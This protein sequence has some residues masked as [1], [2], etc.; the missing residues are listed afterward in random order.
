MPKIA[1][2]DKL[3]RLAYNYIKEKIL[4]GEY[5]PGEKVV[6]ARLSEELNMSRTPIRKAINQLCH[7]NYL[8]YKPNK[9][10]FVS[11][12]D[13]GLPEYISRLRLMELLSIYSVEK[14]FALKE[15]HEELL[16]MYA[17]KLALE[18]PEKFD[19]E[20]F[21]LFVIE[22]SGNHYFNQLSRSVWMDF[23]EKAT[24]EVRVLLNSKNPLIYE[25][26]MFILKQFSCGSCA[27]TKEAIKE[28][29]RFMIL[30]AF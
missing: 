21:F 26:A 2:K 28:L 3:E 6:E 23:E 8:I 10:N 9:G 13:I 15:H 25:K 4:S 27:D 16:L 22:R 5:L 19:L 29:I 30:E 17:E 14:I 1:K 7:A 11:G 24:D 18:G 20:E 12:H